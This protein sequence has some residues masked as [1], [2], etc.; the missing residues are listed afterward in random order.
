MFDAHLKLI[1]MFLPPNKGKGLLVF[2]YLIIT[3]IACAAI[4]GAI[5]REHPAYKS[6][7]DSYLIMGIALSLAAWLVHLTH[8]DYYLDNE[9]NKVFFEMEHHLFHIKMKYWTYIY[10]VLAIVM[11]GNLFFHY[12]P[13]GE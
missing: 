10:L 11:Y 12:F 6:P 4:F 2:L 8:K 1:A 3:V 5:I 9:G 7:Y 13:P